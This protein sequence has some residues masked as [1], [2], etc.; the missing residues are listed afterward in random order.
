MK[1]QTLYRRADAWT[2][3]EY[4]RNALGDSCDVDASEAM[5]FCM[6]GAIDRCYPLQRDRVRVINQVFRTVR[7]TLGLPVRGSDVYS[8]RLTIASWNDQ[9]GRTIQEIRR[10][11]RMAGV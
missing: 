9:A 10:V 4:A 7:K 3:N 6:L 2:R 5:C 1:I 8:R 11:V